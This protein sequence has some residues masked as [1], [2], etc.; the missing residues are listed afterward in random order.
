M[1]KEFGLEGWRK[2][3]EYVMQ[4]ESRVE[5]KLTEVTEWGVAN[6]ANRKVCLF[7]KMGSIIVPVA[8]NV[9]KIK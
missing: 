6:T 4:G 7:C 2:P 3:R 5:D 8:D 9:V 1:P